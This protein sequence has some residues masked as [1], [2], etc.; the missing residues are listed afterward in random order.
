MDRKAQPIGVFDSGVGGLTVASKL[1]TLLPNEDIVYLGDTKR[2]PYGPRTREEI[3][4][5]LI[6]ILAFLDKQKVKVAAIAC[7]TMTALGPDIAAAYE[8]YP[9]IGMSRGLRTAKAITMKKKVAVLATVATINSHSHKNA[10]AQVM[11]DITIVEQSCPALANLIE[12]GILEG[13]EIMGPIQEYMAPVTAS[14]AD[15]AIFGCTHYPFVKTLFEQVNQHIAFVDPAHEMAL[16]VLGRLKKE[17]ALNPSKEKGTVRLCF[18]AEAERGAS[19]AR[20]LLPENEFTVEE[21]SLD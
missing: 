2:N 19:L 11:P 15:T 6:E 21:V 8:A 9:V 12:R 20:H 14:G 7:N 1:H 17:Q 10:A 16:D 5:F 4:Q 3:R 18:T 13:K